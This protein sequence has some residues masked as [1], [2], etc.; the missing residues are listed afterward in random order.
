MSRVLA[1]EAEVLALSPDAASSKAAKG[2]QS[3]SKWPSTGCNDAAAWGECQGSGSK[4]YQTQVDLSGPAFKCSCPSRKFPCKHGLALMLLRAAGQVTEGAEPPEWVN[5]WLGGRQEKAEK[6]EAK[7]AAI[8]AAPPPD[9]EVLAKQQAKRDDKRW[10]K[11]SA[12]MQELSLW[13]QDMVRTGLANQASD[14]QARQHWNTMAARMVDAQATGMAARVKEAWELV[15]SHPHWAR[16]LLVQLGHWQLL[17][18]AVERRESL[19]PEIKA[20]VMAALGWPMDKAE[21]QAQG[22]AVSDEWRAVALRMME[23]EGRLTERRVWLQGLQSGRIA[24][25]LDYAQGGRGFETAWVQGASYKGSLN[26][27]PGQGAL[28]A[29]TASDMQWLDGDALLTQAM[30]G[31]PLLQ[32]SQRIAAS[33]LQFAQPLWCVNAGLSYAE[34]QWFAAWPQADAQMAPVPVVVSDNE[35]WRLLALTGGAPVTLFGEWEAGPQIGRWRLLSAWMAVEEDG[36]LA[37]I[38][39]NRGEML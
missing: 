28:R 24:L 7:A 12:G 37:P 23:R 11:V 30:L 35:A 19:S 27:Y 39:H 9:P 20:D 32:L 5:A 4:P 8:A 31:D 14:A 16:D 1:T 15:D 34:G 10:D 18:D 36:A 3:I 21:V 25:L 6:K 33:P 2:L 17:V 29:L 38:W 22:Q 26:F 13:M